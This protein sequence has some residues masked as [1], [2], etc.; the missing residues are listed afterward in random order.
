MAKG[1]IRQFVAMPLG[2]GYTAEEQVTGTAE[3][4]GLQIQVVPMRKDAF[5]RRFPVQPPR[6]HYT[7]EHALM[8]PPPCPPASGMG[9]APGGRMRQAIEQDPY[10]LADWH[11][12]ETSRC[13][14]H[15]A[16]SLMWRSV[17]GEEAPTVPFT[18]RD[19]TSA[20][21]PWF[22]WYDERSRP[23]Q[24]V[25]ILA[26]LKSINTL[27]KIRGDVPLPENETVAPNHIIGLRA[28]LA[29]GQVR[30]GRF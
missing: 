9:L 2:S 11:V 18:A 6:R 20:G 14:V 26:K 8:S 22:D 25:G 16:N 10:D 27:G 13:F 12:A 1:E 19:Y 5:E 3:F 30:E 24:E 28:G 15:L 29:P 23:L 21:L 17:T 7:G 4:G